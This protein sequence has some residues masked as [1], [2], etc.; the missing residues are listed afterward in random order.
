MIGPD[1]SFLIYETWVIS[2]GMRDGTLVS[3]LAPSLIFLAHSLSDQYPWLESFN[4][5][6]GLNAHNPVPA[7]DMHLVFGLSQSTNDYLVKILLVLH[8]AYRYQAGCSPTWLQQVWLPSLPTL[9]SALMTALAHAKCGN[10]IST[11]ARH[12]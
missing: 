2:V 11:S 7:W 8:E 3:R 4:L 5:R 6:P 12:L 10:L 9:P 1:T